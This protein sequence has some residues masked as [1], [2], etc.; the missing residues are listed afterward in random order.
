MWLLWGE[1]LKDVRVE[2]KK[3][4]DWKKEDSQEN[5]LPIQR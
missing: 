1:Y 2:E 3:K 5:S 4:E